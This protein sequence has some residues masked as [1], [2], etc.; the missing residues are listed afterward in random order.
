[1]VD[2]RNRQTDRQV[3]YGNTA[4]CTIV[5]CGNKTKTWKS[6]KFLEIPVEI[7][8]TVDFLG[9]RDQDFLVLVLRLDKWKLYIITDHPA[10]RAVG[11]LFACVCVWSN[12]R[13]DVRMM[14]PLT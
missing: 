14:W 1:M 8:G 5:I 9:I 13:P 3:Y 2:D 12:D 4:L 10:G 11:R 6:S 7:S